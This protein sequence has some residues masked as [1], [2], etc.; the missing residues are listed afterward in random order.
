MNK[1]PILLILLIA[2]SL[3]LLSSALNPV[4]QKNY[5]FVDAYSH[6]SYEL[7]QTRN[8]TIAHSIKPLDGKNYTSRYALIN[9]DT[10]DAVLIL[11]DLVSFC[12]IPNPTFQS[13]HYHAQTDSLVY[14]CA[15]NTSLLILSQQ[16]HTVHETI[17]LNFQTSLPIAKLSTEGVNVVVLLMDKLFIQSPKNSALFKINMQTKK[18][19]AQ[20]LFNQ[21]LTSNEAVVA[22]AAGK[23]YNYIATN[24]VQGYDSTTVVYSISL[25]GNTYQLRQMASFKTSIMPFQIITKLFCLGDNVVVTNG[26]YLTFLNQQGTVLGSFVTKIKALN[27]ESSGI[28]HPA[29]TAQYNGTSLYTLLP[30]FRLGI[31]SVVNNAVQSKES[32]G[33]YGD[34]QIAFGNPATSGGDLIFSLDYYKE[35]FAILDT[36]TFQPI[37]QAV[38]GYADIMLTDSTYAAIQGWNFSNYQVYVFSLKTDALLMKV[39]IGTK[40]YYYNKNQQ[41]ITFLNTQIASGCVLSHIDIVSGKTWTTTN[42][43]EGDPICSSFVANA[44]MTSSGNPEV[45]FLFTDRYVILTENYGK[46][47][48]PVASDTDSINVNFRTLDLY[49]LSANRTTNQITASLYSWSPLTRNFIRVTT[50]ILQNRPVENQGFFVLN[51]TTALALSNTSVTIV[52]KL[53]SAWTKDNFPNNYNSVTVFEDSSKTQF[54]LFGYNNSELAKGNNGPMLFNSKSSSFV[55]ISGKRS[56]TVNGKVTGPNSFALHDDLYSTIGLVRFYN[57][58]PNEKRKFLSF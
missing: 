13:L 45:V 36:K 10:K 15:K 51:Q 11:S 5:F 43:A 49:Y 6:L 42:F 9:L 2:S 31:H 4:L 30:L 46:Q 33:N 32:P 54:A 16:D 35:L 26:I 8:G 52:N 23:T 27:G 1:S 50:N 14:Y 18:L 3:S 37:Y 17:P 20:V 28:L 47:T 53:N 41:I 58:D 21:N 56:N 40:D 48:F 12:D 57:S 55:E 7:Y 25:V 44:Q 39:P 34:F 29:V 24:K 22:Y 38:S 19:T